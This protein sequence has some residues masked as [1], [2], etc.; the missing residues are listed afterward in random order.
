MNVKRFERPKDNEKKYQSYLFLLQNFDESCLKVTRQ[1]AGEHEDSNNYLIEY[2]KFGERTTFPLYFV[3]TQFYGCISGDIVDVFDKKYLSVCCG[4]VFDEF[5]KVVEIIIEKISEIRGKEYEI[6]SDY[7][8][9]RAGESEESEE[10]V[11]KLPVDVLMKIS[12]A[13]VSFNLIVESENGLFVLNDLKEC[14]YENLN[15]S[16]ETSINDDFE[17]IESEK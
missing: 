1:G 6:K 14:F 15:E 12:W 17:I 11:A 7:L 8:K 5:K 9:I 13:V 2:Q 16:C 3:I 10:S 4:D